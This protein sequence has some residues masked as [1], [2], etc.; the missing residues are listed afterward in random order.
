MGGSVL[1][2][3]KAKRAR[4]CPK[5]G[6]IDVG[7]CDSRDYFG[8]VM[9]RR[10]CRQCGRKWS[11]IEID[12][13]GNKEYL[14]MKNKIRVI[15]KKPTEDVG[16]EA[17][18]DNTLEKIQEIVGGRIE[19]VNIGLRVGTQEVRLICNESGKLAGLSPNFKILLDIIHG[20]VIL[21][22]VDGEDFTDVP[23]N[24]DTWSVILQLWGNDT[25]G[26]NG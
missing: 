13:W 26:D 15:V 25:G 22:G 16:H 1:K 24:L 3:K 23:V 2:D 4:K 14:D 5:C 12:F 8:D 21:T 10:Y 20:P 19:V 17:V 7:I 18:I 11:T 9:R 6:S